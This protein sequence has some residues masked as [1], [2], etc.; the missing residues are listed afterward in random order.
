MARYYEE[1]GAA[2]AQQTVSYRRGWI[3]VRQTGQL[4]TESL[5]VVFLTGSDVNANAI[6]TA[7]DTAALLC[8][9]VVWYTTSTPTT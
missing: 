8:A 7:T 1:A 6:V 3:W 9:A 5:S 4:E 2:I